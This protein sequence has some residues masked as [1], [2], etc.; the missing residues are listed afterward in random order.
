MKD[1]KGKN[2]PL[3]REGLKEI[4]RVNF[5]LYKDEPDFFEYLTTL[6]IYLM[7]YEYDPDRAKPAPPAGAEDSAPKPELQKF[8]SM[9]TRNKVRNGKCPNCNNDVPKDRNFCP[10][11]LAMVEH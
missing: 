4:L 2:Q 7:E 6:V 5:E 8:H 1:R 10:Y 3:S 9:N 11:C